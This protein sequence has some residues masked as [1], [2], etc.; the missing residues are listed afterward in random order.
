MSNLTKLNQVTVFN[1]DNEVLKAYNS[2][3][4]LKDLNDKVLTE[5]LDRFI[6]SAAIAAG[7]KNTF[8]DQITLRE[9]VKGVLTYLRVKKPGLRLQEVKVA[10]SY[11]SYGMFGDFA[12][13]NVKQ[14]TQWIEA[15]EEDMRQPAFKRKPEE[16]TE[17]TREEIEAE[18]EKLSREGIIET[19]NKSLEA[20]E[21]LFKDENRNLA[22][23]YYLE[24]L[25]VLK[26]SNPQKQKIFAEERV[27]MLNKAKLAN[28]HDKNLKDYLEKGFG[29]FEN[30]IKNACRN[31]VFIEWVNE[32]LEMEIDIQELL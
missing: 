16:T 30:H 4:A 9:T 32:C 10:I 19:Y 8:T 17:R 22:F 2:G 13:I 1:R 12:N 6:N 15:Y 25:K 18:N 26:V 11:G 31:R 5:S 24:R 27:K 29:S 7:H 14:I 21:N 20:G 28:P 3:E 23:F